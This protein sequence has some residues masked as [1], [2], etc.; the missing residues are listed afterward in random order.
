[1]YEDYFKSVEYRVPYSTTLHIMKYAKYHTQQ[2]YSEDLEQL[3]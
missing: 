3:K 2:S 1:M